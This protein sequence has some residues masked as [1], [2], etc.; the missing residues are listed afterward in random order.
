[1]TEVNLALEG[2]MIIDL[3]VPALETLYSTG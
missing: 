2:H 3:T 1:M